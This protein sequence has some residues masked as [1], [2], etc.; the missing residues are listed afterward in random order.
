M[1]TFFAQI[2]ID[3]N[4]L[5]GLREKQFCIKLNSPTKAMI[6]NNSV[7]P[8]LLELYYHT[9]QTTVLVL[10]SR[11]FEP[12]AKA[13]SKNWYNLTRKCEELQDDLKSRLKH[14]KKTSSTQ[15]EDFK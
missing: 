5:L 2:M 6:F 8:N 10:F 14:E 1:R 15:C 12:E 7:A 4:C 13:S 9:V 11:Y 3:A